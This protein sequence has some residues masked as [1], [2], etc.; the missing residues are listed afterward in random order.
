MNKKNKNIRQNAVFIPRG[1]ILLLMYAYKNK[2]K[3]DVKRCKKRMAIAIKM[4]IPLKPA[5][6]IMSNRE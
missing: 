6:N 2:A 1:E 5:C 3:M 4:H